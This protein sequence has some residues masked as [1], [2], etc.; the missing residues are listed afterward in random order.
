MFLFLKR[1]IK[2]DVE[3]RHNEKYYKVTYFSRSGHAVQSPSEQQLLP[4]N[5]E[6]VDEEEINIY[7]LQSS[8]SSTSHLDTIEESFTEPPTTPMSPG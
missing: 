1:E 4:E 2:C 8:F 7:D 6:V 5:K 3:K